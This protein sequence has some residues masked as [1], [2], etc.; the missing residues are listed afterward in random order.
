MQE[1]REVLSNVVKDL[2][3]DNITAGK[4]NAIVNA[5][6]K[7]LSSVKLEMEYWKT[8]GKERINNF[9]EIE[10]TSKKPKEKS[11]GKNLK[12]DDKA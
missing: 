12:V 10:E 4:G 6:G 3:E 2:Q 5:T 11:N 1:I 8:R 7:I 9:I